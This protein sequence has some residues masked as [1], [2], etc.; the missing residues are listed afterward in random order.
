MLCFLVG[1]LADWLATASFVARIDQDTLSR[2]GRVQRRIAHLGRELR[3]GIV[4][5]IDRATRMAITGGNIPI[6]V[7]LHGAI[8]MTISLDSGF[9]LQWSNETN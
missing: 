1:W 9:V 8:G 7:L 6:L 4:E 5:S 3:E 2:R